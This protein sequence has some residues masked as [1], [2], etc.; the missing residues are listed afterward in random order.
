MSPKPVGMGEQIAGCLCRRPDRSWG[1]AR[2]ERE[3]VS[4]LGE[5]V[6]VS[7]AN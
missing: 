6:V 1:L 7:T 2:K 5:L 4:G 3:E